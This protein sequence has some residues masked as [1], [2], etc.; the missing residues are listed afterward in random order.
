MKLKNLRKNPFSVS[1]SK[2][3]EVEVKEENTDER[4]VEEV[5]F[6]QDTNFNHIKCK[7]V[8][9]MKVQKMMKAKAK[10]KKEM[11]KA[12]IQSGAPKQV[13]HT[14]ESLRE[15]DETTISGDL[16]DEENAEIKAELM[17]DE[18]AAYYRKD[19]EPKVLITYC[20]NPTRKTRIFGREL[21]RI[22]PNSLSLY[23]NRSGV[24][25]MVKS[26]TARGFT[27]IIVI[28]EDQCQPNGMLV[29]HLPDGP[30]AQFKLSNVKITPELKRSHKEITE[31][32]PEV[33][34]N[35]FTTRL[36][37]TIGRMLGAL[38]HYQPEFKGRRA[39]T[40]HNQRDY[41]FFRH[42]R[43]EFNL[44]TGKPRLRELGPRFTLR[45]KSL[46]HGTF[47]SKYG[48]YEWIIQGKRHAMET[49]RRKFFL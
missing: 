11:K 17:N 15:K 4:Q 24:K 27:D 48:E 21:T 36:G 7:A 6:P 2:D 31:H 33:I 42:H 22:I 40:F 32:R 23:R 18:F 30:T 46:Q 39:V 9:Q 3:D 12:R 20:D 41:I 10:A 8:R 49:S 44:K 34:L 14:I 5:S 45:L 38:F 25:K 19:Y 29:V 16:D 13:P 26:A 28:N 1:K 35:N 43:Y 47:D 37:F